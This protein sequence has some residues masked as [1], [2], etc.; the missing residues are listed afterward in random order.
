M[1]GQ[2]LWLQVI[3]DHAL[4]I[5]ESDSG[6]IIPVKLFDPWLDGHRHRCPRPLPL[7]MRIKVVL[8]NR[9]DGWL[10]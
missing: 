4:S 7:R 3:G 2:L 1:T 6:R 9:L 8:V 5:P 10:W